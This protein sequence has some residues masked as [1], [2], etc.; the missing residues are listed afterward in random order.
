MPVFTQS[1]GLIAV[2]L[3]DPF[4]KNHD[5]MTAKEIMNV[6]LCGSFYINITSFGKV[7]VSLLKLKDV[8]EIA[9]RPS[10]IFFISDEH[11]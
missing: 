1:P 2:L 4:F 3:H 8:G 11:Y 10:E 9:N 7:V 6:Y 5:C